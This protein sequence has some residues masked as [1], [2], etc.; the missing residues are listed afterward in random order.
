M[1][2][3]T[4]NR[5]MDMLFMLEMRATEMMFGALVD[6]LEKQETTRMETVDALRIGSCT[7]RG[8]ARACGSG[9]RRYVVEGVR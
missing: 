5:P 9:T 8:G 3:T 7:K 6:S 4:K 1:L 2:P